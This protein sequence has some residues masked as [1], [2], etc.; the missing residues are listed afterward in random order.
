[1]VGAAAFFKDP[2]SRCIQH[3]SLNRF[4]VS[5]SSHSGLR[6][7]VADGL[8]DFVSGVETVPALGH[9]VVSGGEDEGIFSVLEVS[10]SVSSKDLVVSN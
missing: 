6:A 8:N 10:E 7:V 4:V 9:C 3:E 1:M 2:S 5:A